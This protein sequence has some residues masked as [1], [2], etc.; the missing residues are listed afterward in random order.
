MTKL[1]SKC[2]QTLFLTIIC[3][4]ITPA[5]QA[6][7]NISS[8]YYCLLERE[9]G[10]VLWAKNQ[11]EMRPVASTTKIMTAI[12]ALEYAGLNETAVV[13]DHADHTPEYTIGLGEGQTL[14]VAELTKIAL[15]RS[16]NDAAVV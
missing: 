5:V 13:S 8:Q 14:T 15:I 9:T 3:L 1:I 11:D 7:P 16:A 6:A 10:Q 2:L 12:V 4:A